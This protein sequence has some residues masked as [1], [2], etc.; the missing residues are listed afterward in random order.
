MPSSV[1]IVSVSHIIVTME[2]KMKE[3]NVFLWREILWQ[4]RLLKERNRKR[5]V[6][7]IL[8]F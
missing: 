8:D 2:F 1:T 4:L 6:R 7:D 5:E 3:R